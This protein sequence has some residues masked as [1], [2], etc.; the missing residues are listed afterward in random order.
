VIFQRIPK[1]HQYV[2]IRGFD[3]LVDFVATKALGFANDVLYAIQD[4]AI[5]FGLFT[6]KDLNI[7]EF[8]DH[9]K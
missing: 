9:N 8:E 6:R 2:A 4:S 5:E 7:G 3:T 1:N